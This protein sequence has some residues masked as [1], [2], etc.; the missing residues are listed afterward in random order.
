MPKQKKVLFKDNLYSLSQFQSYYTRTLEL[1]DLV[2][3]QA[4]HDALNEIEAQVKLLAK[5]KFQQL[6]NGIKVTEEEL[7]SY[8]KPLKS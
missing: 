2:T 3:N 6:K 8:F 4:S 7:D 5:Y 1:D